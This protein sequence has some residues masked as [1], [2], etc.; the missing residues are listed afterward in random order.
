MVEKNQVNLMAVKMIS[1]LYNDNNRKWKRG[2]LLLLLP[3]LLFAFKMREKNEEE[4][5]NQL[6]SL[7]IFM[8]ILFI[9]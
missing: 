1:F 2:G 7:S 5:A 9:I 6:F 8:E 4:E 3:P